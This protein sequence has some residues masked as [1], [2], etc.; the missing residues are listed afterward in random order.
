ME[1]CCEIRCGDAAADGKR[2]VE[3]LFL[4]KELLYSI[5]NIA[6]TEGH[7]MIDS[8]AASERASSPVNWTGTRAHARHTLVDIC[9]DGNV[10]RVTEVLNAA[11]AA[12][13]EMLYPYTK[14]EPVD[15]EIICDRMR[16]PERYAVDMT[17]PATMSRTT[18]YLL[19]RLIHEYMVSMALYDWLCITKPEAAGKWLAKAEDAKMKINASKNT[20]TGAIRRRLH[21][22]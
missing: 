1:R 16:E 13:V 11:H 8:A 5:G 9:E 4:R 21:P 12:V 15:G 18:L 6:Y 7:V 22:F 10:D 17:V 2:H 14:A 20:R 19:A 3:L